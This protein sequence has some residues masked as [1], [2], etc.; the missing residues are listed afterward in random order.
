MVIYYLDANTASAFL[1]LGYVY[2]TSEVD[3]TLIYTTFK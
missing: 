2:F 1:L 3:F